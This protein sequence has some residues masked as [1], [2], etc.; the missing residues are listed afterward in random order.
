MGGASVRRAYA[1]DAVGKALYA[2]SYVKEDNLFIEV[3][4]SGAVYPVIIDPLIEAQ[5]LVASDGLQNNTFGSSVALSD[6]G[7]TMIV[8]APEAYAP[9]YRQGAVYVFVRN[10]TTWVEEQ[11]IF[12]SDGYN[13]DKFGISVALSGDGN[14]ALVSAQQADLPRL[15]YN[16]R[17]AAYVFVR[18][19][20]TWTEQQKLIASDGDDQDWFGDST[21]LSYDGNTAIVGAV[22]VEDPGG[23]HT[24]GAAY[25]FVRSG[26]TWTEQ[27]RLTSSG[28]AVNNS[29]AFGRSV[30]LSDD[31]N[32]TIVGADNA[33]VNLHNSQG[34]AYVFVRS[35]IAWTQQQQISPI[36]GVAYDFF[37][38][39]VA[40]S[41]D[42]ATALVGSPR[43]DV[44]D[45]PDQ[46]AAYVFVRDD[47][48]WIEQDKFTASD[49][50]ATDWF[51]RSVTL[52]RDGIH[53]LVG[54]DMKD[55]AYPF[56]WDGAT[57]TTLAKI[58]PLDGSEGD[59][60]GFSA[61][62]SE[63]GSIAIVGRPMLMWETTLTRVRFMCLLTLICWLIH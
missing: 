41:G 61:A 42:G 15:S 19:G 21:A 29:E 34:A 40:L 50:S 36:D 18:N 44:G 52:S 57:W 5:K 33:Q 62:L 20:S 4:D 56:E 23:P 7:N 55:A 49:G 16:N 46:G 38:T 53:A 45:N 12:S 47:T 60:F 6:D 11:K 39:S 31:G 17:G 24:K 26:T 3:E 48:I 2:R 14:T 35:G 25:T 37:G 58:T 9:V 10:G 51:G 54:T 28:G 13:G 22:N 63:D 8:G 1:V 43:A 32:T 59:I 30:A 27:Q